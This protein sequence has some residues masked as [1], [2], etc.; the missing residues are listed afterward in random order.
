MTTNEMT[1]I[2]RHS[3]SSPG[4]STYF[5]ML[6]R[7]ANH[8]ALLGSGSSS[9]GKPEAHRD[10]DALARETHVGAEDRGTLQAEAQP[11]SVA[12]VDPGVK[13]SV[14]TVRDRASLV[15][16]RHPDPFDTDGVGEREAPGNYPEAIFGH[17]V[18]GGVVGEAVR[19]VTAQRIAAAEARPLVKRQGSGAGLHGYPEGESVGGRVF[20]ALVA[21]SVEERRQTQG[22]IPE[23]SGH[24]P[25]VAGA[26]PQ[27]RIHE[28][29]ELAPGVGLVLAVAGVVAKPGAQYEAPVTIA[30]G[31]Q[32]WEDLVRRRPARHPPRREIVVLPPRAD[33]RDPVA[34]GL[35]HGEIATGAEVGDLVDVAGLVTGPGIRPQPEEP[36]GEALLVTTERVDVASLLHDHPALG[37]IP[38]VEPAAPDQPVLL[39]TF[40]RVR[41]E[42]AQ[43]LPAALASKVDIGERNSRTGTDVLLEE[44]L[45]GDEARNQEPL[46]DIPRLDAPLGQVA[47]ALRIGQIVRQRDLRDPAAGLHPLERVVLGRT[48]LLRLGHE[49]GGEDRDRE[50]DDQSGSGRVHRQPSSALSADRGPPHR[51]RT[52]QGDGRAHGRTTGAETVN[53]RVWDCQGRG[54]GVLVRPCRF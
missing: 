42:R 30:G 50:G 33:G 23:R 3:V 37:Q 19:D 32:L 46:E 34:P 11:D 13:Q 24:G 10:V 41:K 15:E 54:R 51:E 14:Q 35:G 36:P 27:R 53:R 2:N 49:P 6:G 31:E 22:P 28:R 16:Q 47:P 25:C 44:E 20:F 17:R 45:R 43:E 48:R 8:T 7:I 12:R 4:L 39:L 1:T 52:R 38:M 40:G 5:V 26:L 21:A 18:P 9:E 29:A